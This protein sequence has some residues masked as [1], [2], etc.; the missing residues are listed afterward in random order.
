MA[1]GYLNSC[2]RDEVAWDSGCRRCRRPHVHG[3]AQAGDATLDSGDVGIL[4]LDHDIVLVVVL[5]ELLDVL[6]DLLD[7]RLCDLRD[8]P[9]DRALQL[10]LTLHT[11][12]EALVEGNLLLPKGVEL[13]HES[14]ASIVEVLDVLRKLLVEGL[15]DA[16]LGAQLELGVELGPCVGKRSCPVAFLRGQLLLDHRGVEQPGVDALVDDDELGLHLPV[17]VV[18]HLDRVVAGECQGRTWAHL[19][20]RRRVLDGGHRCDGNRLGRTGWCA[21]LHALPESVARWRS[22]GHTLWVL[23]LRTDQRRRGRHFTCRHTTQIGYRSWLR[24]HC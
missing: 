22:D 10:S 8:I 6:L 3:G 9:V 4:R 5:L 18:Y 16:R 2:S 13:A 19:T 23:A 1:L 11:A 15:H 12:L 20:L 14:D 7:M 21:A 17:Q 24:H